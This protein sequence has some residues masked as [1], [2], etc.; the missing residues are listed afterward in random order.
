MPFEVTW[1]WL[2]GLQDKSCASSDKSECE[3]QKNSI[4]DT[5]QFYVALG[6]LT[7][8]DKC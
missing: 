5:K 8:I 4:C 6:E 7:K 1:P 2:F 3:E